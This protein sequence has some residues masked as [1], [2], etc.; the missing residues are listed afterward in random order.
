MG[1]DLQLNP[2]LSGWIPSSLSVERGNIPFDPVPGA[3]VRS[4]GWHTVRACVRC[5]LLLAVTCVL[6]RHVGSMF[7]CSSLLFDSIS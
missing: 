4:F 2:E 7:T 5:H 6:L 1:S 3:T